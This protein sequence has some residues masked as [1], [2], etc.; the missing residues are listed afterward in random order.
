MDKTP[1]GII[2]PFF[3]C[4]FGLIEDATVLVERGLLP[5]M[6]RTYPGRFFLTR[7]FVPERPLSRPRKK[8][9]RQLKG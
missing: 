2:A 5:A 9:A 7:L 8:P 4:S 1:G 6:Y 3:E